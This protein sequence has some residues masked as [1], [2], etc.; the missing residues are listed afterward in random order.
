MESAARGAGQGVSFRLADEVQGAAAAGGGYLPHQLLGGL[1]QMA[2]E[3]LASQY[4]GRRA[5]DAYDRAV[6]A[7]R[8][9]NREAREA[10]P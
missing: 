1:G 3:K 9:A 7:E 4:V 5:T 8:A 6:T 10:N 2:I